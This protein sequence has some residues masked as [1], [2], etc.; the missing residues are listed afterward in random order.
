MIPKIFTKA[1]KES[2]RVEISVSFN[3]GRVK[4]VVGPV[5]IKLSELGDNEFK[6]LTKILSSKGYVYNRK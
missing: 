3:V 1:E 5:K 2:A 4:Q 6:V